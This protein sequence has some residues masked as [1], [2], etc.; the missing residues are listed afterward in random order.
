MTLV[1]RSKASFRIGADLF[2]NP[3]GVMPNASVIT[4]ALGI[5]PSRSHDA[6]EAHGSRASVWKHGQWALES[7]LPQESELEEH[8]RWLLDRLL[9]VCDRIVEVGRADPRLKVDFFCGLWLKDKMEG[10]EVTPK[11]LEGIASLGANLQL[12]IYYEGD[13]DT[14]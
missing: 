7:P 1:S 3:P 5:Q 11:T 2:Y 8:L 14:A 12:D 13:G 6:G 9:P 10:L 4:K